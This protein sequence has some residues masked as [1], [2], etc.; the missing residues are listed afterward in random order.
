MTVK[1]PRE[2]WLLIF[3][4]KQANFEREV[5]AYVGNIFS[6]LCLEPPPCDTDLEELI[7]YR[8]VNH[9]RF[10]IITVNDLVVEIDL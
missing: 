8:L 6:Q 1:L 7:P 4:Y 2:I 5:R 9:G 3:E 10:Q